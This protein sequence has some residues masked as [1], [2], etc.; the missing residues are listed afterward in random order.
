MRQPLVFIAS[1][2]IKLHKKLVIAEIKNA[3]RPLM[4]KY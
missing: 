2:E 4:L 1:S 3:R